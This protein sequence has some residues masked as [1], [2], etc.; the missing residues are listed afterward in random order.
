M[1]NADVLT[2]AALALAIILG[3]LG[4]YLLYNWTLQLRTRSLL[5]D[6][7]PIRSGAFILVYF[8]TPTC[9]PCKTV[10]RPAIQR[11]SQMLGNDLHVVEVDATEQPE[12][13]SRWGVMSV[14][15]TFL[16]DPRGQLRHVNHGVARAEKLLMQFRG[17]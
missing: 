14:P 4:A 10:Q 15:T 8:T 12:L 1:F 17:E 11:L 16:F 2:R 13:A 3:G 7:G 5:A 9:A 6:L